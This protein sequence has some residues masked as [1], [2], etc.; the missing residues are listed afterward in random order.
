MK[1][2][3]F[4]KEYTRGCSNELVAVQDKN[5]KEVISYHEWLTPEQ[6]LAAVEI[7]R[8]EVIMK[9]CEWIEEQLFPKDRAKRFVERFRNAIEENKLNNNLTTT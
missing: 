8:E 5:G 2:E 4:I 6:A 1:A 7:A 3:E 9:A